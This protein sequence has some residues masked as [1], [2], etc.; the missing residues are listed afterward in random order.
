VNIPP[1]IDS[2]PFSVFNFFNFIFFPLPQLCCFYC[3]PCYLGFC[4]HLLCSPQV[5]LLQ[6]LPIFSIP[7][8]SMEPFLLFYWI[9]IQSCNLVS[10]TLPVL[11]SLCYQNTK[12]PL[13]SPHHHFPAHNCF[14]LFVF[15][16]HTVIVPFLPCFPPDMIQPKHTNNFFRHFIS[17]CIV[18]PILFWLRA[19][20][21]HTI[22]LWSS[23]I[24]RVCYCAGRGGFSIARPAA[25]NGPKG[26][27]WELSPRCPHPGP[28]PPHSLDW[29]PFV[30]TS[31][32][33]CSLW[34][35]AGPVF[36]C[37]TSALH[38]AGWVCFG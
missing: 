36:T 14:S 18:C 35:G 34:G 6:K 8:F 3:F 28:V 16:P 26:L 4:P 22:E 29:A 15:G 13:P 1:G 27:F 38:G 19:S 31:F 33:K 17:T 21:I 24:I 23:I 7:P 25:Y 37:Q 20:P 10:C 32:N 5:S 9:L 11:Q 12:G 2:S 30:S